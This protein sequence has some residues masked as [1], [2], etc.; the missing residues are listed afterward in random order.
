MNS[1]VA[2]AFI[3]GIHSSKRLA[4]HLIS[5]KNRYYKTKCYTILIITINNRLA[6][7]Y[8]D[9]TETCNPR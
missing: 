3:V 7:I 1:V 6:V 2:L 5:Q 4:Y 8:L 9:D